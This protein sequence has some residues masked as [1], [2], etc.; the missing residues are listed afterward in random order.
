[1]YIEAIKNLKMENC[2]NA[3]APFPVTNTTLTKAIA[4]H[5]H[6]PF[7]PIKVPRKALS[8]LLGERVEAILMSNNTSA[9]K[10]LDAG[11]KFKFT[12]LD[13]ALKDLYK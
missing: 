11:F 13:D 1:M 4:K 2:Y 3:C 12:H 8:L 10:I 7:W 9:Q 6:R 5:L